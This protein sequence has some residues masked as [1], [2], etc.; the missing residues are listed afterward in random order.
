MPRS[1]PDSGV[2]I[3]AARAVRPERAQAALDYFDDSTRTYLTSPFVRLET[4][5]K[6][7]YMARAEELAFYET[8]FNDSGVQWCRDWDRMEAIAEE[9]ARKHGLGALDA[10]HAA[11]AHLLGADE[12]V[13]TEGLHKPLHRSQLVHVVYLY[14]FAV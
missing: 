10:L 4:I 7:H 5:P 13:T 3:D 2:L 11:A 8:F 6:A 12:L 14:A 1:F 9:E